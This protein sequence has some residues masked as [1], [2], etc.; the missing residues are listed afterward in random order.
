MRINFNDSSFVEFTT[1]NSG[2]VN[3]ILSAKDDKNS[4]KTIVNSAEV[5]ME[6][7]N[8]LVESILKVNR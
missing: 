5:S 4:R 3:I 8:L 6:D 7:F 1:S 2:G